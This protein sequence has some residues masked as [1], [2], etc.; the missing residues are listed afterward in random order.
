MRPFYV[1]LTKRRQNE[2]QIYLLATPACVD[3]IKMNSI[4]I[5]SPTGD[6]RVSILHHAIEKSGLTD[7]AHI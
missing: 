4:E 3:P 2:Y 1:M 5:R 7:G 6:L